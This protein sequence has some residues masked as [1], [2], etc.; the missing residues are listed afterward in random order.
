MRSADAARYRK[1]SRF[2][3]VVLRHEPHRI[4]LK[5]DAQGWASIDEL[6]DRARA[7]GVHL[8]HDMVLCVAETSDKQR[9]AYDGAG[10]I[11]ANHG[12]TIAIDLGLEPS[13]PPRI[14]FHG[15]A[16]T[17]VASIRAEGLKPGRRQQVHL[18]SN[19]ITA[20]SVG[21]RHGWPV[22]LRV[23]ARRMWSSGFKFVRS[24]SGVWLTNA[25]P[26]EFIQFPHLP[27]PDECPDFAPPP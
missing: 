4:G 2:L 5:L 16:A 26:A 20:A 6:V 1:I 7:H 13:E 3:S 24:A 15:T 11:R 10:R 23:A 27:S 8:T 12:H 21:R 18:S 25:V 17:S 9:F 19:A 22:V 14:L